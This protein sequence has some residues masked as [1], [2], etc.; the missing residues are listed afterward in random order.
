MKTPLVFDNNDK[1]TIT[2]TI[3][4]SKIKKRYSCQANIDHTCIPN[5]GYL[6]HHLI[7]SPS[8]SPL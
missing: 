8:L 5:K 4:G 6:H 1:V 7:T 3:W 2:V